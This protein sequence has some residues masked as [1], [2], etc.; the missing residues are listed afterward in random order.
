[1]DPMRAWLYGASVWRLARS[2]IGIA[3][4]LLL[5]AALIEVRSTY[6]A[7]LNGRGDRWVSYAV[8]SA[9]GMF[10][11][12]L[13]WLCAGCGLLTWLCVLAEGALGRRRLGS[14]KSGVG[15]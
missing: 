4:I 15:S 2:A 1:M 7:V 11:Y 10:W 13:S 5:A 12:R 6:S 3:A 8:Y 14:W 9:V